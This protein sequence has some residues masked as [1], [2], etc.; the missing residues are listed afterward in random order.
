MKIKI[1]D[2]Y[3]SVKLYKKKPND[4]FVLRREWLFRGCIGSSACLRRTAR[5]DWSSS[6]PADRPF[7]TRNQPLI[8]PSII[9][10]IGPSIGLTRGS[11]GPPT[12]I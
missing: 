1:N 6:P 5:T 4:I 9:L 11:T 3:K 8:Q 10:P 2:N 12:R 7:G